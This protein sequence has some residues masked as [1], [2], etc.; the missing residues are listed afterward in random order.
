[1]K[2]RM[3]TG[4]PGRDNDLPETFYVLLFGFDAILKRAS[5]KDVVY[6]KQ[7]N[8][9]LNI[10]AEIF[11]SAVAFNLYSDYGIGKKLQPLILDLFKNIYMDSD[12][13]DDNIFFQ[14]VVR[15]SPVILSTLRKIEHHNRDEVLWTY[16][17]AI[18]SLNRVDL[19]S[20][21]RMERLIALFLDYSDFEEGESDVC[22]CLF[23]T[24]FNNFH[25]PR[26]EHAEKLIL[27]ALLE[28]DSKK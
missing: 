16:S 17:Y 10:T 8:P 3:K 13:Y 18:E 22:A 11:A 12:K 15:L 21:E 5:F 23:C 4:L 24:E 20:V 28:I 6:Y 2:V 25:I 27:N 1:M 7:H 14:E 19:L 9:T 26:S